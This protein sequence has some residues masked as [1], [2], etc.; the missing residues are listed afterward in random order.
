MSTARGEGVLGPPLSS[1]VQAAACL[2]LAPTEAPPEPLED[3]A[4]SYGLYF[5]VSALGSTWEN[6]MGG[7]PARG[8][9]AR[10]VTPG[11]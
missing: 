5:A 2:S 3:G 4:P 1:W 6:L 11:A 7:A 9:C 10:M 8:D